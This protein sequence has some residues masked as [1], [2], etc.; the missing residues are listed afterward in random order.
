MT[1]DEDPEFQSYYAE[2]GEEEEFSSQEEAKEPSRWCT[3]RRHTKVLRYGDAKSYVGRTF[4]R[5]LKKFK[6]PDYRWKMGRIVSV[7]RNKDVLNG[8]LHFKFY[9]PIE[10]PESVPIEEEAF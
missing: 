3:V 5:T 7:V 1:G 4:E 8:L 9:N 10:F 2:A 6:R